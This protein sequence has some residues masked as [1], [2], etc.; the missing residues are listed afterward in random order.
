M[1]HRL[2]AL[3]FR[4]PGPRDWRDGG[5]I[6][7]GHGCSVSTVQPE[8]VVHGPANHLLGWIHKAGAT[9]SV[10]GFN[11][12]SGGRHRLAFALQN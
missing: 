3:S 5:K 2:P 9:G 7:P 1:N 11:Q 12:C 6:V 4:E 8:Q 10:D